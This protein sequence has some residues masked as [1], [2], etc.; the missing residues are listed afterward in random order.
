MAKNNAYRLFSVSDMFHSVKISTANKKTQGIRKEVYACKKRIRVISTI[1]TL[2]IVFSLIV[3]VIYCLASYFSGFNSATN[4]NDSVTSDN[5]FRAALID[6]LYSTHPNEEF[7][8]S[9]NK[10]L[11]DAGF[12]VDIF[13]G[14]QVTVDF[15]KKLPKGYKLIILRMH[16]ALGSNNQLYLFTAEPYSVGKYA[17]EQYFQL[18]KEAYA[19]ENSQPVFAVNWA[20]IKRCMTGKF[21]GTLVV[22]MGCDG[23]LDQL[24]IEEFLNQGAVGYVAW[25]GPVS[26]SH[27]D[28]AILY[29]THLLYIEKMPLKE[30]VEKTNSQIGE[31][32]NWGCIL[33]LYVPQ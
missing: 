15:L 29:L 3:L 20:F 9:F 16:S 5:S 23:T 27:S 24:M 14:T 1:I 12:E 21:N 4:E 25:N 6:A 31:D 30:A 8:K 17:Q 10:T 26:L 28:E 19:T 33:E 7:T 32:P 2:V 22:M 11:S 13:Q 18:V